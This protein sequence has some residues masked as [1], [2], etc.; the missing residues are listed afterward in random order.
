[1]INKLCLLLVVFCSF[2]RAQSFEWVDIVPLNIQTNPFY[3]HSPVTL[4]NSG[5]PVCARLVNF[6]QLYSTTYFGD[7]KIEK[8]N[9]TGS[10]MWENTIFGKA[11][12]SELIVDGENNV[13]CIGTYRDSVLIGTTTLIQTTVNNGNFVAK[14]DNSGNF[15]WVKDGT[16]FITQ[17]GDITALGIHGINSILIGISDFP[18]ESKILKLDSGG[19]IVSSIVQTEVAT[20]S[21]LNIDASGNIWVT[22]FTFAGSVSFNGLSTVAPFTYNDYVV[23][24]NSFGTT[25]W[26]RFIQDITAQDFNIETDSSGNAYLSGNLFDSTSFGNL[27]ANGPQWIYDYFVTKIGPDGDFIWLNEIPPGN[28]LGDATIGNAN[29]LSCSENGD[30][31]I[32]GFF[33]GEINFGNGVTLSPFDYYDVFVISYNE[34]GEV[35]WAKAAGSNTFDQ[36]SGI[37]VNENGTCYISGLVSENSVFDTISITGGYRNLYLARLKFDNVVNVENELPANTQVANEFSLIQNYP[38]PFN[39]TTKISWQSP[40][41]SHQ[42]L[43]VYDL[44]GNEIATLVDEYKSAGKYEATFNASGLSSGIYFYRLRAGS[45][46]ETRKMILMK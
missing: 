33:R 18:I 5:N 36:G 43:I 39:P 23:K 29:F 38:N 15:L 9:S 14:F 3:L 2:I 7:I 17:Y 11:D 32:T 20:V 41:G 28:N 46:I 13:V 16:E 12:V 42:T 35:Q 6:R 21:D 24:Y 37:I 44:L 25:Q 10:L 8:R 26:V 40:V 19:N 22:G 45:F 4:D 1:M 34:D 27:H 31:Y 30:T